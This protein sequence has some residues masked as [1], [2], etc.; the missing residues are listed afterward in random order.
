MN[1]LTHPT[2]ASLWRLRG[3]LLAGGTPA[4]APTMI[5]LDAFYTF[6]NELAA[7]ATAR[8]YSHYA[9]LLDMGAIAGVALQNLLER[10]SKDEWWQ[11]LAVGALSESLMILA[12]R[13][14]VKAWE[15]EMTADF[16]NAAWILYRYYWQLSAEMQPDLPAADRRRLA[17]QLLAPVHDPETKST[18]KAVLL[19][20]LFQ[21][22]L[23]ASLAS[24]S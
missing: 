18:V 2:P 12:A 4:D 10:S 17:D 7:S 19:G 16:N 21:L 15:N 14:Y 5:L 3:D 6:L 20:C 11:R 8:E 13:Q 9:S 22:L 23:I 24:E 1:V